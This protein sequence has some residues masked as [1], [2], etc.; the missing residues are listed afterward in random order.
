M[1]AS[2]LVSASVRVA[3]RDLSIEKN[4]GNKYGWDSKKDFAEVVAALKERSDKRKDKRNDAPAPAPKA[5][6]KGKPKAKA[7]A[8]K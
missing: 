5:K 8:K 3:L 2:G 7:K 4:F 6:A 1:E